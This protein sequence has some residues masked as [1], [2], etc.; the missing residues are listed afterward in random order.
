MDLAHGDAKNRGESSSRCKESEEYRRATELVDVPAT[1]DD[2][3]LNLS[4]VR[5]W[6]TPLSWKNSQLQLPV[7]QT[8][9]CTVG[10]Y[11]PYGIEVNNRGLIKDLHNRATKTHRLKVFSDR[12]LKVTP[13]Q[14]ENLIAFDKG[15]SG[16]LITTKEWKELMSEK[17]AVKAA[18]NYMELCRA[19]HTLDSGPQILFKVM[20]EKFLA[21]G[22]TAKQREDFFSSVTWELA[23]RAAKSELPY[24]HSELMLKWDQFYRYSNMSPVSGDGV[25]KQQLKD[26]VRQMVGPSKVTSIKKP[27]LSHSWCLDFNREKGCSNTK[28]EGGGC[29]DVTGKILKHGCSFRKNGKACNSQDHNRLNHND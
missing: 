27:R 17:D 3:H 22:T 7:E 19:I 13:S 4:P 16:N 11:E 25:L 12:N 28:K 10:D 29:T 6:R 8:P 15:T 18:H 14:Q 24:K 1:Q 23:N 2:C 21:G 5:F 26:Y 20:L 9:V